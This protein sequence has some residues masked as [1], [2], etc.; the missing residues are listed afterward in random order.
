MN[1]A[2]KVVEVR[3]I[4][5]REPSRP[6]IARTVEKIQLFLMRSKADTHKRFQDQSYTDYLET[7]AKLT[8]F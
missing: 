3:A 6:W 4:I 8:G 1:T 5:S 7:M 2:T